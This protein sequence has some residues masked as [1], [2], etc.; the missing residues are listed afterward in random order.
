M[1]IKTK[2]I[3]ISSSGCYIHPEAIPQGVRG[4]VRYIRIRNLTN[5]QNKVVFEETIVNSEGIHTNLFG[6]TLMPNEICEVMYPIDDQNREL[7]LFKIS[8]GSRLR[9]SSTYN[10]TAHIIYELY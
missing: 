2:E 6:D 7:C 3:H 1:I 9:V 8:P 4:L 5:I 10:I